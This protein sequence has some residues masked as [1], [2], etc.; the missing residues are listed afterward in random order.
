MTRLLAKQ[1]KQTRD[2]LVEAQG[3]CCALC[4]APINETDRVHLD[5]NHKTGAVRGALHG[6]CNMLLG[7][8]ENGL[9]RGIPDPEGFINGVGRY[10]ADHAENQTGLLHPTHLT[11]EEKKAKAKRRIAK[12]KA[13]K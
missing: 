9:K 13:N 12:K 10:L 11:P 4:G 3:H 2:A 5:H 7:K 6:Q 1:I 8:L